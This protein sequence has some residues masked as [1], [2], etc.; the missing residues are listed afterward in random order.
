M[1]GTP[2]VGACLA[3]ASAQND[4]HELPSLGEACAVASFGHPGGTR[5]ASGMPVAALQGNYVLVWISV[6]ET[7]PAR[8]P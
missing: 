4:V 3:E 8:W 6:L 5:C 2:I 1:K 7:P